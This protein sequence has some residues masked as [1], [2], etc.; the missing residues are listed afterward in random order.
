MKMELTVPNMIR[1]VVE[2]SLAFRIHV[3]FNPSITR[4]GA[5]A[6]ILD[7]VVL[8][9]YGLQ[10]WKGAVI[11]HPI[12]DVTSYVVVMHEMGHHL[13]PNG[14]CVAKEPPY[15][16]HPRKIF[17]Y[18]ATMLVSEEAAWDWAQYYIEQRFDWTPTMESLKTYALGSYIQTRRTGR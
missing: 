12:D 1:H 17:E 4:E 3:D 11:A 15:G 18:L 7:P 5:H 16:C 9:Q 14:A 2:L 10:Y 8:K 6:L 13:A